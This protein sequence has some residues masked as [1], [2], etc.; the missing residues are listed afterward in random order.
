MYSFGTRT[1][2]RDRRSARNRAPSAAVRA[3]CTPIE[4]EPSDAFRTRGRPSSS[5]AA[6]M[7]MSGVMSSMRGVGTA[8]PFQKMVNEHL[9]F[10][11]DDGGRVVDHREAKPLGL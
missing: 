1:A 6:S 11:P 8:M 3:L 5:T 2:D 9:V 7:S 4:N 10:A